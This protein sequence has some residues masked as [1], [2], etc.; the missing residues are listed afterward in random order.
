MN[1]EYHFNKKVKATIFGLVVLSLLFA[2]LPYGRN[3]VAH[4]ALF[5]PTNNT[6]LMGSVEYNNVPRNLA[7]KDKF[8][9]LFYGVF[10]KSQSYD[11]GDPRNNE[12]VA[13]LKIPFTFSENELLASA[14]LYNNRV[15]AAGP[16]FSGI[17]IV[18]FLFL[19]MISFRADSRKERYALYASYL[20]VSLILLLSLLTPAP[21]LMHYV[22]QMQLLPFVMLIPLYIVF[23]Q[24]YIKVVTI[25]ILFLVGINNFIYLFAV[26]QRSIIETNQINQE[27]AQMRNSGDLYAVKAQ[28]FYSSYVLLSEQRVQFYIVKTM[29]CQD[30]KE[31]ITSSRTTQ[32]C[33]K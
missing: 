3:I 13:E 19:F 26:V 30:I 5:Y 10:S 22:T 17:I 7:D 18:S 20:G 32:Y 1:R 9:L 4:G 14:S 27:F 28:H 11:S 33:L 25:S 21:N 29:P 6:E 15:G 31:M 2:I 8:T 23:K 12:N 24:R 16:L